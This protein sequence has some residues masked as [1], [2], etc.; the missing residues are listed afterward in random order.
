MPSE[1]IILGISILIAIGI[2][3][4]HPSKTL[5]LPSLLIF[6]GVGLVFGNGEFG[7]VYDD[8]N[9]TSSIGTLAL[10]TIVFVGGLNTPMKHIQFAWKEG[11][12]LSTAGAG[13]S[14]HNFG[15]P[16]VCTNL[17]YSFNAQ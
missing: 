2:L 1:I 6:M 16:A 10:N 3:L 5:G 13:G 12:M 4:H 14:P 9:V 8:L 11:G 7:F 15:L 17:I